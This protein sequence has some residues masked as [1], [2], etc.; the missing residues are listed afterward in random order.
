M[1]S[2]KPLIRFNLPEICDGLELRLQAAQTA[3]IFIMNKLEP[4]PQS[5]PP[6]A[7]GDALPSFILAVFSCITSVT[8]FYLTVY[9]KEKL[10]FS[11]NQIGILFSIQA[12]TGMLAVFPAGFGN[13]RI[14]SRSLIIIGM[15]AQSVCLIM[16][17]TFRSYA[18]MSGIFFIWAISTWTFRQ[19]IDAQFLK[20]IN[21]PLNGDSGL[22]GKRIGVY[23]AWRFI[24]ATIGIAAA[25]QGIA[26]FNYNISLICAGLACLLLIIP[27]AFLPPRPVSKTRLAD[28]RA[29]FS[30]PDVIL[31]AGW[32]MLFATHWGAE[33]TCYGLF[34]RENLGLGMN[35]MGWYMSAEFVAISFT[36]FFVGKRIKNPESGRMITLIGLL[37][38]GLGHIGMIFNPLWVSIAFRSLHGI[39]D[40]CI[41]IVLYYGI[42]K[43]FS[44]EHMGGNSGL[45]NLSNMIGLIAGSLIYSPMGARYGY[46]HPLWISGL[47]TLLLIFPLMAVQ[48]R[49][50][51]LARSFLAL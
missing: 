32:M 25:G 2:Q 45:L 33:Q 50:E 40:G 12:V 14:T 34:I 20:T 8:S 3:R 38:S 4:M 49:R 15:M 39:G 17:G 46:E 42:S 13:D 26:S 31:F 18:A 47:I 43:L 1:N 36:V 28:Y 11:P 48:R 9:F 7:A 16:M 51:R 19:S 10:G 6:D 21:C 41:F 44:L 35:Q 29:N 22:I 30:K 23:Q 27:A 37:A 24:G 5:P